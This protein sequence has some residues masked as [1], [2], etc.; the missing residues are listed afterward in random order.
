MAQ[1]SDDLACSHLTTWTPDENFF[2]RPQ[3]SASTSRNP[4]W[5]LCPKS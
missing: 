1:I 3:T 4:P 2:P 5:E